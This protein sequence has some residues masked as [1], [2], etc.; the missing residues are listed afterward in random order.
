M[1]L[2]VGIGPH[3]GR[4]LELMLA[5]KKPCAFFHDALPENG[6]ISEQIILERAFAPYVAGGK[7]LR[8]SKE[9]SKNNQLIRYVCFTL[10]AEAWRADAIFWLREYNDDAADRMIGRLL[11]Y[12]EEQIDAFLEHI[13]SRKSAT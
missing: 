3:E 7:F 12:T 1:D 13:A 6:Q 9:T 10:P 2:P 11:G 4:E 8:F 5:G